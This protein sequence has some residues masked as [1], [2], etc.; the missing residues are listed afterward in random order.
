MTVIDQY[1][2][3]VDPT[4][5][6]EL[7]RIRTIVKNVAPEA[8]EV[9]SYGMPGFKYKNK[10]LIGFN[11]FK[12][13]LSLFPTSRPVEVYKDQLQDYKLSEVQY[14]LRLLSPFQR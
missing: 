13:H 5:R 11:A 1:F 9:I 4:Q 2:A 6:K 14:S 12:D 7:E 10:Y 3:N 8:E